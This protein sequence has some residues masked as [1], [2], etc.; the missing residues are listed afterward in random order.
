[1]EQR[2]IAYD[3]LP[4]YRSLRQAL[5]QG[6]RAHVHTLRGQGGP[7]GQSLG[8][9]LHPVRFSEQPGLD[10]SSPPSYYKGDDQTPRAS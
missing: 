3:V 4:L 9:V 7:L 8:V 1:M 2:R 10:C 6:A 5:Q